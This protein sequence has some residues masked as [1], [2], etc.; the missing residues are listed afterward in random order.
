M[1]VTE[2]SPT[3]FLLF[4]VHFLSDYVNIVP[5]FDKKSAYVLFNYFLTH[6]FT[7]K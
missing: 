4:P 2:C 1:V 5:Y 6:Y 7:K 3:L